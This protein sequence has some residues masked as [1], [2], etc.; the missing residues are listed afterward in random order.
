M[1]NNMKTTENQSKTKSECSHASKCLVRLV[2]SI[3]KRSDWAMKC[4]TALN[5]NE[6]I[7]FDMFGWNRSIKVLLL[8]LKIILKAV[9]YSC[10]VTWVITRARQNAQAESVWTWSHVNTPLLKVHNHAH[11]Y[12]LFT[13]LFSQ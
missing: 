4:R 12:V 10:T 2:S 5:I 6:F 7:L 8:K 3:T 1:S 11:V 13:H 9:L